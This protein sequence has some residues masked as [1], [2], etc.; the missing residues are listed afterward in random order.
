MSHKSPTSQSYVGK[1]SIKKV[2][3]TSEIPKF[4]IYQPSTTKSEKDRNRMLSKQIVTAAIQGKKNCIAVLE[5]RI[6]Q[7]MNG[8]K[9]GKST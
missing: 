5:S 6:D 2:Q 9:S 7:L 3:G 4:N 8:F 1:S